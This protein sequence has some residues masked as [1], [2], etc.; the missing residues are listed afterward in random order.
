MYRTSGLAERASLRTVVAG[1]GDDE[2]VTVDQRPS[3]T[4]N[5]E[6]VDAGLDDFLS[7]LETVLTGSAA[8]RGYERST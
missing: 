8:V 3:E 4:G 2:V 7:L 6:T 5:A 1:N